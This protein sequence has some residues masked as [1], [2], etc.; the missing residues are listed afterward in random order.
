MHDE[1]ASAAPKK[2]LAAVMAKLIRWALSLRIVRA[3]LQYTERRGPMLADAVTYRALFSVFAGVLL[4]FSLAALWLSS[5]AAAWD[6]V[7]SAVEQAIP[8]LIGDGGIVDPADIQAPAGLS[9]AGVVSLVALVGAALGAIGSLR[10]AIRTMAG[11]DAV[12]VMWLWVVLR[13]LALGIGIAVSFLASAALTFAGAA[14]ISWFAGVLGIDEDSPVAFWSVRLV[15]LVVVFV[16]D[17]AL[18]AVAF[19]VLSGLRPSLRSLLQGAMLGGV[20][21]LVLQELSNLFVGGATSNPLLASFASLLA[22]LIWLN[23]STQVILIASSYIATAD[24]EERDRVHA[25]HGA[26]TFAQRKVRQ[27]EKDVAIAQRTLSAAREA[28]EAERTGR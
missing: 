1:S 19:R 13:N 16:L 17:V 20:G 21:L 14:A 24:E 15:S 10:I 25:R 3:F 27:A 8:G 28:E 22:L 2:G 11:T 5:N 6:A 4:G 23:L 26:Q 9:I 18:I 7:V 12:D